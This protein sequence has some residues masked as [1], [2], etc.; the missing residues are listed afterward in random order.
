MKLVELIL[1]LVVLVTTS[2]GQSYNILV[3]GYNRNLSHY[4]MSLTHP[5]TEPYPILDHIHQQ[6]WKVDL[7]MSWLQVEPTVCTFC[8]E[9]FAVHEVSEYGGV[10]GGAISRWAFNGSQGLER[11]E[12]VSVGPGPAHLLVDMSLSMAFSA[13][14]AAG[15]WTAVSMGGQGIGHLNQTVYQE[16]FGKGCR[17]STSHPHETVSLGE[18][19][20]VV[21]LGCDSI[22]HY[23]VNKFNVT[24]VGVTNIGNGRGPRHMTLIPER[25]LAIV[26]CELQNYVQLHKLD[27]KSSNLTMMQ[28][29]NVVSVDKNA[30]AEVLVHPNKQWI[31]ISSRGVGLVA[32][33]HLD[34]KEKL[35][36]V[37]EFKLNGT[38]PR[39]M[40]MSP[41]GDMLIVADQ[42]GD[43]LHVLKISQEDGTLTV[44]VGGIITT[45]H[46]PS[47]VTFVKEPFL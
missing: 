47:Y 44:V 11:Q 28:E 37:Q 43:S 7:N 27:A 3:S 19:V 15:S 30:G 21:D 1:V 22:Y 46:Q 41:E 24:K 18:Y 16:I 38:W 10:R 45:P 33:F 12:W 23:K 20:W 4:S 14:Y 31:Y 40:A 34:D 8:Y 13:N 35:T 6:S 9:I 17:N 26:V 39:S 2:N 36:K 42:M 25:S 29:M 32:V 5:G